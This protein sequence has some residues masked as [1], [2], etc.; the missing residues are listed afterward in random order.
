MMATHREATDSAA[1][2]RDANPF[3][4]PARKARDGGG[5]LGAVV[6]NSRAHWTLLLL[7]AAGS[8]L[9]NATY[10]IEGALRPGYD[11]LRQPVSALS[12]GSGGWVQS[13]NF[14]VFGL[15]SCIAAF[16]SRPTLAPGMGAAW[17]PR[18]RIIAGLTLIVAGLFSQDPANGYPVGATVLAHPSTHALIHSGASYVSLT[19]TVAELILLARRFAREPQWRG[20]APAALVAGILMMA[21]LAAFG[22]LTA[23]GGDG[24]IFEKLASALP[25]LFGIALVVRLAVRRDARVG[26]VWTREPVEK[27]PRMSKSRSTVRRVPTGKLEARRAR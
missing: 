8:L 21:S 15:I 5:L 22:T 11:W 12:L 2:T 10:L 13:T 7:G 20:W 16:A 27:S 3:G 23:A 19:T 18:L 17:Y 24:G 25:S 9:F 6:A 26:G 14:I 1:P 4:R